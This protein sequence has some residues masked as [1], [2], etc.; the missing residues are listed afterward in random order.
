MNG[1]RAVRLFGGEG[2]LMHSWKAALHSVGL[3]PEAMHCRYSIL[4]PMPPPGRLAEAVLLAAMPTANRTHDTEKIAVL[5]LIISSFE[6][7]GLPCFLKI[8]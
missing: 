4:Q 2:K 5:L 1:T 8:A 7:D 3:I 6:V